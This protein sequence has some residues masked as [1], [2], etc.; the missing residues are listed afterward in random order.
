MVLS[1]GPEARSVQVSLQVNLNCKYLDMSFRVA[2][3]RRD[4]SV[5][6]SCQVN[7][8]HKRQEKWF[9]SFWRKHKSHPVVC[10][11]HLNPPIN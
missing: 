7:G 9:M 5:Q 8:N 3:R 6:V 2:F 10:R 1:F 4:K 11:V